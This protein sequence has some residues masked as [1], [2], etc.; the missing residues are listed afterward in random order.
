I[1]NLNTDLK[2]M[3]VEEKYEELEKALSTIDKIN[4]NE[5]ILYNWKIINKYYI[6]SNFN[7]LIQYI[8]F[9][10]YNCY[11]TEIAYKESYIDKDVYSGMMEVYDDIYVNIK[12]Q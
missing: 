12:K 4:I 5:I 6:E 11:L 2:E 7:V 9:V 1:L 3:F 8:K 10:A